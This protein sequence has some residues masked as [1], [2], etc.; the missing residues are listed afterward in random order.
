MRV[1]I[2]ALLLLVCAYGSTHRLQAWRSDRALWTAAVTTTPQLPEAALRLG[3]AH[4]QVGR[5]EDAATWTLRAAQLTAERPTLARPM[6]GVPGFAEAL[7]RQAW[8]ID[9]FWPIC[10]RPHW[11]RACV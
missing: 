2:A 1:P 3:A 8:F 5:W 6:P 11:Q 10:H 9:A 7:S 4:I